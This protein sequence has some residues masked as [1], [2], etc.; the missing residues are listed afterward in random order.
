MEDTPQGIQPI[1]TK[2]I[3]T[4]EERQ[5]RMD[6]YAARKQKKLDRIKKLR[7]RKQERAGVDPGA[8]SFDTAGDPGISGSD[9]GDHKAGGPAD[10]ATSNRGSYLGSRPM[11]SSNRKK[12]LKLT[13]PTA[14]RVLARV[15]ITIRTGKDKAARALTGGNKSENLLTCT[16]LSQREADD[17]VDLVFSVY[18]DEVREW[19]TRYRWLVLLWVGIRTIFG[20]F[21]V[22]KK[23]KGV[24][25]GHGEQETAGELQHGG[26]N[27]G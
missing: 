18:D 25:N 2:R 14:R 3:W 10:N 17:D 9:P 13:T 8:D 7:E 5:R 26:N 24:V 4:P 23:N 15:F 21:K 22:V 16:E 19:M 27:Q 12:P 1:K 20:G 11:G 6:G